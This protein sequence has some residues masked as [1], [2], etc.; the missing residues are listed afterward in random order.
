[1]LDK[2]KNDIEIV[3]K[4]ENNYKKEEFGSLK[5]KILKQKL[6]V[7]ENES[8][9]IESEE[10]VC[11]KVDFKLE[12]NLRNIVIG[13]IIRNKFGLDIFSEKVT[14]KNC[15]TLDIQ[16]SYTAT[17][18]FKMPA[19]LSGNYFICLA[20]AERLQNKNHILHWINDSMKF[21]MSNA[22]LI[23]GIF[24]KREIKSLIHYPDE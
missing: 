10:Y 3:D 7:N 19:L 6:N 21:E 2:K 12:K 22:E 17:F 13:F 23:E 8:N 24:K 16:S 5:A 15:K 9:F 14:K 18:E 4:A 1:M 11:I 20:L